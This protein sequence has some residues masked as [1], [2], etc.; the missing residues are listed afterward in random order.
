MGLLFPATT[1]LTDRII[2]GA[3]RVH[4]ALGPGLLESAYQACLVRELELEG[5]GVESEVEL[6]LVYRGAE[7]KPGFRIDLLVEGQ[8][9]VELKSVAKLLPVHESQV[10]TYLKLTRLSTGLL[11]NFNV[12][13]LKD[14]MRRLLL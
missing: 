13:V 10:L 1:H 7:V 12:P 11:F 4:R 14:G 8:V 9:I 3:I 5:L 6:P 2:G